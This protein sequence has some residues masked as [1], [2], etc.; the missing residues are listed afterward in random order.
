MTQQASLT[1]DAR[2]NPYPDTERFERWWRW[3]QYKGVEFNLQL[4]DARGPEGVGPGRT[5]VRA[6]AGWVDSGDGAY[7]LGVNGDGYG[8]A[9]GFGV[10][11]GGVQYYDPT[12]GSAALP[13]ER[14]F[15]FFTALMQKVPDYRRWARWVGVRM[16]LGAPAGTPL[17]RAVG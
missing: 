6:L 8:H 17:A 2:G 13:R 10:F 5:F 15:A 12:F 4:L 11:G 3:V 7:I 1:R 16:T 9:V 14:A